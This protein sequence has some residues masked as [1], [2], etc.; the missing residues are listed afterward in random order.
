MWMEIVGRQWP[1]ACGA[2]AK[3]TA[4]NSYRRPG[5]SQL[6]GDECRPDAHR[7]FHGGGMSLTDIVYPRVPLNDFASVLVSESRIREMAGHSG[8]RG[9]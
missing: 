1:G 3:D 8:W 5:D 9:G 2:C 7:A 4:D 6:Y